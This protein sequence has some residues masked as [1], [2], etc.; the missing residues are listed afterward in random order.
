MVGEAL[1]TEALSG[2]AW[3]GAG[4]EGREGSGGTLGGSRSCRLCQ[5]PSAPQH[6]GQSLVHSRPSVNT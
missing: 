5:Y 3:R 4:K 2:P 1:V 6:S